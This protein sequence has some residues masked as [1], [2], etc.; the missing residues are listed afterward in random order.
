[1]RPPWWGRVRDE[2]LRIRYRLL[3][4]NVLI[5]SVP[6]AG[7][8]F[9][10]VYEREQ[11]RALE[12]DMVHQAQVLRQ[13]ILADPAILEADA[14]ARLEQVLVAIATQTRARIRVLDGAG[15]VL[16]DSHVDG[17]PEGRAEAAPGYPGQRLA[18]PVP[19][20]RSDDPPPPDVSKRPEVWKALSGRYGSYTRVWSFPGGE[21]V[22]LFSALPIGEGQGKSLGVIYLTRSTLPVLAALYRLRSSLFRVLVAALFATAVLSLF[23][24]ATIARPLSRLARI[25]R[26]I[27]AGDRRQSLALGRH[28]EI[29]HLARAF[30]VMARRLDDRARSAAQMAADISHEFK[31]PLTSIRGAAELLLEGASEDPRAR[32]RFLGNILEDASRLDR[33]VSRL[34]ELSRLEAD[35][36]PFEELPLEDFL[37]G[38]ASTA[39]P[40]VP[41]VVAQ[42]SRRPALWG[43][44]GQLGSALRNLVE[45]A[46]QHAA[47]GT[48]VTV[49]VEDA[50]DG[51][52]LSV[53]NLGEA[54]SEANLARIWDRFFTTRAASGGSGLGL[55]I[56]R[57][58]V[59]AHGGTASVTSDPVAGTTFTVE[60]PGRAQRA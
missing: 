58:A 28:D 29:G 11:L 45:N 38:L 16:G 20:P 51:L 32:A 48:A 34:L 47:P 14:A 46:R 12:E 31:S 3:L 26:R 55:P 43:R 44:R 42:R 1:M 54:I 57:A 5:V 41:V 30:D 36:A 2:L 53:H 56:V 10:R 9:A 13:L 60:L 40:G 49:T 22:F 33:L 27:A 59:A 52:R 35:E 4:V 6:I 19:A 18:R 50:G 23:L 15:R 17:P 25:A 7:I 8:A 39:L 37:A 21:R 24:A